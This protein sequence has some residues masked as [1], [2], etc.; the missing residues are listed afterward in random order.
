[1]ENPCSFSDDKPEKIVDYKKICGEYPTAS[2]FGTWH[3]CGILE[4]NPQIGKV[5]IVTR[6]LR[7][8]ISVIVVNNV[9]K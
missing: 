9:S 7:E 1:M 2:A 4:E 8:R 6:H 5:I 3:A